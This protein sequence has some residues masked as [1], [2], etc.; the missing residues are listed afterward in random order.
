V[1][2]EA[3]GIEDLAFEIEEP[4]AEGDVSGFGEVVGFWVVFG[5]RG[6]REEGRAGGEEVGVDVCYAAEGTGSGGDFGGQVECCCAYVLGF[7]LVVGK[8]WRF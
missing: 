2:V 6:W 1:C 7:L 4:V 8:R 3:Q 5:I